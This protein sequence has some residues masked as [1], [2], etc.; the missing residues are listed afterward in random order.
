MEEIPS[1]LCS[2]FQGSLY[3]EFN[4]VQVGS[5]NTKTFRL[6]NPNEKRSIQL[7]LEKIPKE[8]GFE[9]TLGPESENSA[10]INPSSYIFGHVYW[11][12][13]RDM[14][15]RE[16]VTIKIDGKLTL[17]VIL[18]GVAGIGREVWSQ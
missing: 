4:T 12:P 11:C 7:E 9:I 16:V 3:L 14:A 18:H 5:V 6:Q 2:N 10:T 15:L 1:L 17:Q 8:K 13:D